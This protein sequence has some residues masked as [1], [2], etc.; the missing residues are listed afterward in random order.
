VEVFGEVVQCTPGM[1]DGKYTLA[2]RYDQSTDRKGLDAVLRRIFEAHK[3][4]KSRKHP[5][6]PIHLRANEDTPFSPSYLVKDFSRGGTGLEIESPT[7]PRSVRIGAPF[8]LE[9]WIS[10]GTLMLHGEVV[11]LTQPTPDRVK[12][13]NPKFGVAFG[14]LRQDT[15]DRLERILVLRG[16]PPPPW[17]ARVSFGMDAVSRMP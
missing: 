15:I 1:A 8:L 5:R 9:V 12:W 7:A 6:I 14:K 4:E 10:L 16:L 3:F 13:V 11:W 2:V 17:R